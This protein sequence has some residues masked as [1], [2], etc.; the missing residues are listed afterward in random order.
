M[1]GRPNTFIGLRG[2]RKIL[3]LYGQ[4]F[5][6]LTPTG[7]LVRIPC[8]LLEQNFFAGSQTFNAF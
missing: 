4:Q 2:R 5:N 8:S 3:G 7:K 1:C 6:H